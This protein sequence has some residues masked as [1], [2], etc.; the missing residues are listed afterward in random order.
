MIPDQYRDKVA[1]IKELYNTAEAD[2]KN[3]G[4]EKQAIVVTGIN[5]CRYVGQHLLRALT[6]S[7]K[8][9]IDENLDA[10]L[11][12]AQRAIYDINDSGIQYYIEQIDEIRL[13]HFPTV[14]FSSVIQNYS[15]IIEEIGEARS[16][17]ETTAKSLE[18]REQFYEDAREHVSKLRKYHQLLVEYRPD[19]VRAVKKE[20]ATK[21]YTWV[22][23]AISLIAALAL[24]IRLMQN[25]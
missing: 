21:L 15:E 11:R 6:T 1:K 8:S 22:G 10:A 4:R 14:D 13:K 18:N 12:H 23:I 5:Q 24:V 9:S 25:A 2:L 19:L 20:N 16:L 7:D 3:V 17:S